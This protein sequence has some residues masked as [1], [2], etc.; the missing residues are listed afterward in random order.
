MTRPANG[1]CGNCGRLLKPEHERGEPTEGTDV[2]G[3]CA[4]HR[5]GYVTTG[6]E[7]RR[8]YRNWAIRFK[9]SLK[10]GPRQ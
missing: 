2:C 7:A 9:D 3:T 5:L 4:A 6:A 1:K 10:L 8:W